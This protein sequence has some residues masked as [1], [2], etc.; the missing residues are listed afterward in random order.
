MSLS[1]ILHYPSCVNVSI[2]VLVMLTTNAG[3]SAGQRLCPGA[4]V[5]KPTLFGLCRGRDGEEIGA[6]VWAMPA[7]SLTLGGPGLC[8]DPF[9]LL[10]PCSPW[11]QECC[12]VSLLGL[13]IIHHHEWDTFMVF[14][15]DAVTKIVQGLGLFWS[16]FFLFPCFPCHLSSFHWYGEAALASSEITNSPT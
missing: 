4:R 3:H 14:V 13:S 15:P 5:D 12:G 9:Y 7:T 10:L 16:F 11:K 6:E 8:L 1:I 2:T